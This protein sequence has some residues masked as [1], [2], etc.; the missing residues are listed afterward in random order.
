[1]SAEAVN[2]YNTLVAMLALAALA[3][4]VALVVYRM[5]KG[6]EAA[7]GLGNTPLWFAWLV[8]LVATFG[9]LVYSE[10]IH[11]IPCRLCWYQRIAMYP[12]SVVLL[13][14]ALRK[15][16]V[17]KYYGLPLAL[18]GLGISI[19]HYLMQAF[20]SLEGGSC[21]LSIPCSTRYVEMFGFVSI[22]F[23]AGSGFTLIVVLLA[24]YVRASNY[25]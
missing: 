19:W 18:G 13:V 11:F 25:E 17:A 5:A 10:A 21:D 12:L 16:V 9:S 24:F 22:P 20:P 15:E 3:I 4:A 7:A 23:M 2:F 6:P 1:M 14:G 8:A